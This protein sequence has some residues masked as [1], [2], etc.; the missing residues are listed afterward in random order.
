MDESTKKTT[1]NFNSLTS[2][3]IIAYSLGFSCYQID[4]SQVDTI[5]DPNGVITAKFG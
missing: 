2:A 1:L 4:L 5:Y 3:K